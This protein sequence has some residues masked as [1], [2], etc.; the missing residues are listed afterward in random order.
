MKENVCRYEWP[1]KQGK[2]KVSQGAVIYGICSVSEKGY[3][4]SG[5]PSDISAFTSWARCLDNI[6]MKIYM[7][8]KTCNKNISTSLWYI[9]MTMAK[10]S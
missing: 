5:M 3:E 4:G 10:G 1:G 7:S 9:I 8:F 2:L 6:Y